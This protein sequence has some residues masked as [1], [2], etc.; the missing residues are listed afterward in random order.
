MKT[1]QA[2]MVLIAATICIAT[3][4]VYCVFP[5]YPQAVSISDIL[6][7][8]SLTCLL[9]VWSLAMMSLFVLVYEIQDECRPR[10]SVFFFLVGI[11]GIVFFPN[12][13]YPICHYVSSV[14][15]KLAI[16]VWYVEIVN[17]SVLS[18]TWLWLHGFVTS[19]FLIA[20]IGNW[21]FRWSC[22]TFLIAQ[23]MYL[24]LF[25]IAFTVSQFSD[26]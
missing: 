12:R 24:I 17:L 21:R 26:T 15:M 25:I 16:L 14:I 18:D 19:F 3:S 20:L 7:C 6:C 22:K 5:Q 2:C 23:M 13:E 11:F 10:I 4:I 9:T 1:R 8:H